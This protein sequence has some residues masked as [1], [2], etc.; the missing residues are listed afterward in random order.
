MLIKTLRIHRSGNA[1]SLVQGIQYENDEE[2][3][4]AVFTQFDVVRELGKIENE[5]RLLKKV[6]AFIVW[7]ERGA[8]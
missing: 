1:R 7:I 2:G 6:V 3:V 8:L 4:I 5:W